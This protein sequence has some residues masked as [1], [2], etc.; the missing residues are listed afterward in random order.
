[1]PP[2]PPAGQMPWGQAMPMQYQAMQSPG[3]RPYVPSGYGSQP[4]VRQCAAHFMH[5]PHLRCWVLVHIAH[6]CA[7]STTVLGANASQVKSLPNIGHFSALNLPTERLLSDGARN[8]NCLPHVT[9]GRPVSPHPGWCQAEHHRRRS[10][11]LLEACRLGVCRHRRSNNSHLLPL[12]SNYD[13]SRIY[14]LTLDSRQMLCPV[15]IL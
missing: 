11:F 13:S 8:L 14:W 15:F 2:P 1:M 10:S 7:G 9:E 4:M 3:Q 6:S 5:G 12:S